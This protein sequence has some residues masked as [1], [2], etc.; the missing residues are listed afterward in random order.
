ML[1]LYIHIPFCVSKCNYCD[2]NSYKMDQNLKTR[3]LEDLK[4]EM[5]FY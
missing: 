4:I 3:Y 1:G 5:H 2:F